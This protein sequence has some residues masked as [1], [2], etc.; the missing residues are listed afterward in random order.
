MARQATA[1]FASAL[2]LLAVAFMSHDSG[3]EAWCLE[4]PSPDP[5]CCHG[6]DGL[7]Y[8]RDLCVG[9][10]NGFVGGECNKGTCYCLKCAD[11]PPPASRAL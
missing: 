3:V 8:C 6:S 2:L 4:Y 7:R 5:N 11:E 10:G 1:L 9:V